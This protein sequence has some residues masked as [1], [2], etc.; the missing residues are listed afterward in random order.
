MNALMAGVV[1]VIVMSRDISAMEPTTARFWRVMSLATIV[2]GVLAYAVNWWPVST[3]LKHGMGSSRALGKGGPRFGSC[4]A[5]GSDFDA[6]ERLADEEGEQGQHAHA[7][8]KAD[9]APRKSPAHHVAAGS[10]WTA[11]P[12]RPGRRAD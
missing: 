2:G 9:A 4:Q 11:R 7:L 1:P 12:P 8:A 6:Q 10:T 3:G 5:C